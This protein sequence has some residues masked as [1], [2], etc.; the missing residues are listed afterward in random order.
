MAWQKLRE[1]LNGLPLLLAGPILR[2]VTEHAVTVW[3]A[4]KQ[5]ATVT[6]NVYNLDR[7]PGRPILMTGN[8]AT[9][10]VGKNLHIVAVTA[11][12]ENTLSEGLVYFYDLD[13]KSVSPP[14]HWNFSE[15]VS[16]PNSPPVLNPFAYSTYFLPSFALPPKDLNKLRLTYGS[17]AN[18]TVRGKAPW[19]CS[20]S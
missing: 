12:K 7:D 17:C 14:M 4:L 16:K 15:A 1:R 11:R 18:S 20:T 3:V 6:L 9:T 13:F 2:Q 8:R 19:R 10:A 5:K